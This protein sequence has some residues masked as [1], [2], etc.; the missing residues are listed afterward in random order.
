MYQAGQFVEVLTIRAAKA[1]VSICICAGSTEALLLG[2]LTSTNFSGAGPIVPAL[3]V[4][5]C[6]IVVSVPCSLVFTRWERA[7]LLALLC[8]MFSCVFVSFPCGIPG[9]VSNLI[10]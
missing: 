10:V 8:V 2:N 9:Q 3:Y 4:Y 1:L 7:D 6:Y 5:L